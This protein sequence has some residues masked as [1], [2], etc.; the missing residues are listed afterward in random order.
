MSASEL[1]EVALRELGWN[2]AAF[3]LTGVVSVVVMRLVFGLRLVDV[4]REVED[5]HNAAVG[6]AFFTVSLLSG[7]WFGKIG[8]DFTSQSTVAGQ[9]GWSVFGFV[10]ATVVFLSAFTL[11]FRVVCHKRGEPMIAYLR[12]EAIVEDN[13]AMILFIG[14]LAVVPYTLAAMITV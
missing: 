3:A 8:G 1:I 9:I 11:V 7:L 12:R 2:V 14:S 5:D 13:A 4:V 10:I 6:A